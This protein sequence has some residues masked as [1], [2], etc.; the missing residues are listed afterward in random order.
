MS[1]AVKIVDFLNLVPVTVFENPLTLIIF[2]QVYMKMKTVLYVY[3]SVLAVVKGYNKILDSLSDEE[4]L[5]FKPLTT[6]SAFVI[7]S[8]TYPNF[9]MYLKLF[10]LLLN[11]SSKKNSNY[12]NITPSSNPK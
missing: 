1:L 11:F 4:R 6:V 12:D 2:K 9:N 10:S 8:K 3:E 5:L 7:F